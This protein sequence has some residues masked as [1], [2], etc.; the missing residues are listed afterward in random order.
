MYIVFAGVRGFFASV[1]AWIAQL[2]L[3]RELFL[4][5]LM[6]PTTQPHDAGGDAGINESRTYKHDQDKLSSI[7]FDH[8]QGGATGFP[9]SFVGAGEPRNRTMVYGS[10]HVLGDGSPLMSI[11]G[12][13]AAIALLLVA[14][15]ILLG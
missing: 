7:A 9:A 2:R 6:R 1:A 13:I 12:W 4:R 11:L 8:D 15:F 10:R 5:I 3:R 14:A